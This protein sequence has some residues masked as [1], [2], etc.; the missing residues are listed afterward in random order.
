MK[1]VPGGKCSSS[2]VMRGGQQGWA[3]PAAGHTWPGYELATLRPEPRSALLA[4]QHNGWPESCLRSKPS[5]MYRTDINITQSCSSF[6]NPTPPRPLHLLSWQPY[7]PYAAL[8]QAINS[9]LFSIFFYKSVSWK[10]SVIYG[11]FFEENC[12][13]NFRYFEECII[14]QL[15]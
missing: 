11:R 4:S 8:L 5:T 1:Y 2:A 15:N 7:S 3:C 14:V 12:W 13:Y 9:I 10:F 6:T